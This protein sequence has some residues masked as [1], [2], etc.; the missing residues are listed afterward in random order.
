MRVLVPI[1]LAWPPAA[2]TKEAHA[3]PVIGCSLLGVFQQ[4][5]TFHALRFAESKGVRVNQR[6]KNDLVVP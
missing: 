3:T 1:M 2:L 6:A 5:V 4:A